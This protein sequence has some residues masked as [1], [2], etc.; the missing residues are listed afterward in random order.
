MAFD[1]ASGSLVDVSPRRL[2]PGLMVGPLAFGCWR[3]TN[4][5][6]REARI[7]IEGALAAGMRLIDTADI[8]GVRPDGNGF[9][10]NEAILGRVL[11]D[12]PSLRREM[13]LAT[14]GG[15][16]P[17]VP[18]DS[19]AAQIRAA[20]EASLRRLGVDV[21]DLYQIH[22]HDLFTH[23]A[24]LAGAV[25]DLVESG[26]VR[27]VGVS[28]FT[29]AQTDALAAMLPFPLASIQPEFSAACLDPVRDGTF[30]WAMRHRV[31][32]LAWSPLAGGRLSDDATTG[33][34]I[35]A[36][37][38]AVLDRLAERE[39]VPR[40]VVALAFVLAH[41]AAPIAIVGTQRPDRLAAAT[42]ALAVRLDRVD[43]Y[44]IIEASEGVALP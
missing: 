21:V 14:K 19:G 25:A 37:L 31:T 7:V 1:S 42:Q 44:S 26:K 41:P 20:C 30:D 36:E 6:V 10:A 18:Y 2:A 3:F 13:V 11:A 34:G 16:R 4:P 32:P 23:P 40:S 15:I 17:G 33:P 38:L 27:H 8:Y 5:D 39:G 9:G 43:C 29:V 28:N 35:R 22:R 24:E 12:A